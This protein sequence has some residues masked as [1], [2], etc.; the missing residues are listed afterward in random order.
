MRLGITGVLHNLATAI[1]CTAML[2][3]PFRP[4][5]ARVV[6]VDQLTKSVV[7]REAAKYT[8][9]TKEGI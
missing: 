5:S 6:L 2:S 3:L 1:V 8:S 4:T 7:D 9:A